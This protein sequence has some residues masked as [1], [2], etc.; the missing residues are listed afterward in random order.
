MDIKVITDSSC[1]LPREIINELG[2]EVVPLHVTF[3]NGE[4]FTEGVTITPE[5]FWE[6]QARSRELPKTSR[7]APEA[8]ARVFR[9]ALEHCSSVIYLG[10]SS[11]LS[12]T[13]ES[14]SLAAKSVSGDIHLVDSLTGSLGLGVLAVRACEY[15]QSGL[16]AKSA[17]DKINEYRSGMTT[18]FT[19]DSLEN[20]IKGGRLGMLPGLVG[21]VLDIKPIGKA[22]ERG[23]ISVM[24]RVR[25]RKKSLKR[26][27]QLLE[28]MGG[29]LREKIV[30]V[31]YLDCLEEA[32]GLKE[33]IEEKFMPRRV[34]LGRIGSTMGTYAGRG[35]IIL[36]F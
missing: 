20:L 5:Q 23:Q 27:L 29:N 7:P 9:G 14:A 34:I 10:I 8:F 21:T 4:T 26:M 33:A 35:G 36:A 30:G 2:I 19:M 24:E 22:G 1:D 6:R 11:A 17:V 32:L 13:F 15:I 28:E 3:E 18:L 16:N 31:S 25:G 12:G